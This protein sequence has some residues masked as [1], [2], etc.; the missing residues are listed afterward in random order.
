MKSAA[1]LSCL[2]IPILLI[3][4][5]CV[6]VSSLAAYIDINFNG[7]PAAPHLPEYEPLPIATLTPA[8]VHPATPTLS[9]E[10]T[11]LPDLNPTAAPQVQQVSTQALEA[12]RAMEIP[13][14]DAL[15]LAQRLLGLTSGEVRIPPSG[16]FEV[17]AEKTFWVSNTD[18]NESFE[19]DA[20]LRQRG[21]HVYFWIESGLRFDQ[22]A[23]DA[24]TQTFDQEIYPTTRQFFGGEPNP[25]VDSDPR[26][27]ILYASDLGFGV[28]GL[29]S[30]ADSAPTALN[31][32]SNEHEMFLVN[33]DV[34]GLDDPYTYGVLAH[35]FQHMIHWH[36][37][38]NEELWIN[39]GLA[40][41]AA[42]LNGYEDNGGYFAYLA[43]PDL[44]LTDWPVTGDTIPHYGASYLFSAYF[45][46]RFGADLTR[47]LVAHPA[48]GL[49]GVAT[50]LNEAGYDLSGDQVFM[51]WLVAAAIQ[52]PDLLDGRY[53]YQ[54]EW[55]FP[56]IRPDDSLS[57]CS[58]GAYEGQV[59]QYGVDALNLDC[60]GSYLLRL[61]GAPEVRV[62]PAEPHSGQYMFWS[63]RN[64]E[65][66]MTLTKLFDFRSVWGVLTL[67]YWTWYDLEQDFD[68]AYVMASTDGEN[69]ELLAP[70]SSTRA[71]P[72][73]NNYGI[74]YN[75]ASGDGPEWIHERVNISQYSGLRVWLRFEYITDA[76]VVGEGLLLDDIA[77]P[78]INYFTD[79]EQDDGGW[80]AAGF[81]RLTNRLPQ[82]YRLAV[83]QPGEPPQLFEILPGQP[84]ETLVQ[85]AA[86]PNESTLLVTA[87]TPYTRQ[88]AAYRITLQ[89]AP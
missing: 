18:T 38:R 65:S 82:I 85:L 9:P 3:F 50:V 21:E 33:A 80:D 17:G 15:D 69:W 76:A 16:P 41:L 13:V 70:S 20:V 4:M 39:E 68:Y 46:G 75:G 6:C 44:Q 60:T 37:D 81:V 56:S 54:G 25:G 74:G 51:D 35:E 57:N 64:D 67:E 11:A 49:E 79:F 24:L 78:E 7:A 73:G 71:N 87:T 34:T 55:D 1:L 86:W 30:S 62:V 77:I 59:H 48:N 58:G 61:E 8:P 88:R 47:A 66:D 45:Y 40:E 14:N 29:Y 52:D 12:I 5:A 84:F 26:L 28:A 36:Q 89:P 43:D 23:V 63:N 10:G 27:H 31:Q 42:A 72:T 32:Y 83:L 53:A 2:M 22:D 19:I